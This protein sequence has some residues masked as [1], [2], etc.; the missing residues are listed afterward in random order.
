MLPKPFN[1]TTFY[2]GPAKEIRSP[3]MLPVL[4]SPHTGWGTDVRLGYKVNPHWKT[5]HGV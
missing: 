4:P 3:L 5:V 1:W 2:I